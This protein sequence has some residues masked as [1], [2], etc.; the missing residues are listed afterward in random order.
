M[1]EEQEKVRKP[2]RVRYWCCWA[3]GV[4]ILML[5][6]YGA[7]LMPLYWLAARAEEPHVWL[8]RITRV[9]HPARVLAERCEG[10]RCQIITDGLYRY[11]EWLDETFMTVGAPLGPPD[12]CPSCP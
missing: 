11:E 4:A 5:V 12:P 2:R 6:L 7:I 10:T 8:E 3:A 1:S 9:Y